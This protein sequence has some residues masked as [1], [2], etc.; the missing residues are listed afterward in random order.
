[1]A[2]SDFRCTSCGL[3]L[4]GRESTHFTCPNCS[5]ATIGRDARCRDQSVMYVCPNCAF[6]G[7]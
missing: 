4:T 1:M 7:P 2:V 5:A 6:E 3:T